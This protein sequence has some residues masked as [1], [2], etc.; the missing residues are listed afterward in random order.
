LDELG[1]MVKMNLWMAK[2]VKMGKL[3][4]YEHVND[5][6][7]NC[8]DEHADECGLNEQNDHADEFFREE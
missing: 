8:T 7:H 1:E 2:I 5:H 6:D 3:G 4:M